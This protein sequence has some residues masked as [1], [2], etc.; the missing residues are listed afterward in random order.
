M[1]K[2][3]CESVNGRM[4]D[5]PLNET[6]FFGLDHAKTR[7]AAWADDYN[8]QRSDPRDRYCHGA[9]RP[10]LR[11]PSNRRGGIDPDRFRLL[12][13]IALR[14]TS[15]MSMVP[16]STYVIDT[17]RGRFSQIFESKSQQDS[18]T[19]VLVQSGTCSVVRNRK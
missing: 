15:P 10:S 9:S 12:V 7:I 14:P 3:F 19:F 18:S 13:I 17:E 2:G 16:R 5:E 1:Q 11:G 6:L 4:R 8:R